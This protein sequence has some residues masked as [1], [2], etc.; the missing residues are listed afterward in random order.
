R[1]PVAGGRWPV[2]GG[3]WPVA[4]ESVTSRSFAVASGHESSGERLGKL[5]V[6]AEDLRGLAEVAGCVLDVGDTYG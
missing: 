1:W 5:P 6:T 2:A 3:R 4:G